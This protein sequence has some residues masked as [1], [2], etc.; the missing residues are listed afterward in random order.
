MM[1]SGL[2][3]EMKAKHER[4]AHKVRA[5]GNQEDVII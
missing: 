2:L 5:H 4:R 1:G 3:A